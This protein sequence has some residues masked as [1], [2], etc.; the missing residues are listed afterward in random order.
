MKPPRYVGVLTEM[1]FCHLVPTIDRNGNDDFWLGLWLI[2]EVSPNEEQLVVSFYGSRV[3]VVLR[4]FISSYFGYQ[5]LCYRLFGMVL[6]SKGSEVLWFGLLKSRSIGIAVRL[7]HS[8]LLKIWR[9]NLSAGS[10]R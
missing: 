3:L 9:V 5:K 8:D 1:L 6:F 4:A 7:T 2:G 10:D